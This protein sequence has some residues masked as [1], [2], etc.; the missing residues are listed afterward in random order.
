MPMHFGELKNLQVLD[1]FFM[2]RNNELGIKQL[3]RLNLHGRL[4]INEVQNILNP[5]FTKQPFFHSCSLSK[6]SQEFGSVTKF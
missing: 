2:D 1:M 5:F 4:F 6:K 3:R